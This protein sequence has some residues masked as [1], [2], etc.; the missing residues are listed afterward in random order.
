[1]SKNGS[2][3][4]IV[5]GSMF[6]GLQPS[7]AIQ[8][9]P[10]ETVIQETIDPGTFGKVYDYLSK[11]AESAASRAAFESAGFVEGDPVRIMNNLDEKAIRFTSGKDVVT[12]YSGCRPQ[13][14]I[15]KGALGIDSTDRVVVSAIQTYIFCK[16]K[17]AYSP[18][19]RSQ[20]FL[21]IDL[22]P[23]RPIMED[24]IVATLAKECME[25][26]K[27]PCIKFVRRSN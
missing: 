27:Q 7:A 11:I 10:D 5:I 3:L 1:M 13:E 23:M 2:F 16:E 25:S 20:S 8:P 26:T 9:A 21:F 18:C 22:R 14:C 4:L 15:T 19:S 12:L 6:L 17:Y 24:A